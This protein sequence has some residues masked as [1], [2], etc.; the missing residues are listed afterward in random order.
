M[1]RLSASRRPLRRRWSGLPWLHSRALRW[2]LGT[3]TVLL[4]LVA[5]VIG[6]QQSGVTAALAA[7]WHDAGRAFVR[8]SV[9]AGLGAR[10][11]V[12]TGRAQTPAK[13]IHAALGLRAGT[14]LLG[15]DAA[16]ARAA[17][18]R[19]PWVREA[20]VERHFPATV[21]VRLTERVPMALWQTQ[22]RFE[23]LDETGTPIAGVDPS[24]FADLMMVVGRDAASHAR[25]LIDVLATEP[26]LRPRVTA[27]VH[28]AH[29]RWDLIVDSDIRVRLPEHG[30][31]AAWARLADAHRRDRLLDRA[32][33]LVDLRLDDR[34]TLQPLAGPGTDLPPIA[35]TRGGAIRAASTV[36]TSNPQGRMR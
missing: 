21:H 8:L 19:L 11:I 9:V 3:A 15:F 33:A 12:V 35:A 7:A 13:D 18:E 28:V 5:A 24:T 31:A 34:M 25:K 30:Y 27:A 2:T 1:P 22:G 36:P 16:A 17:L 29:R 20:A 14:P 10:E 32:V 4:G 6:V 26:D 23:V